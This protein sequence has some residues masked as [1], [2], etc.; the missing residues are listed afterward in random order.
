MPKLFNSNRIITKGNSIKLKSFYVTNSRRGL[1]F[2]FESSWETNCKSVRKG[3]WLLQ[4][5]KPR[6]MKWR[7]RDAIK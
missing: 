1:N 6:E 2:S 5:K 3:H 7:V 4:R